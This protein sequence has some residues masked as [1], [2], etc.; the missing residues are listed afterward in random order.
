MVVVDANRKGGRT[1]GR[2]DPNRDGKSGE[3]ATGGGGGGNCG[4]ININLLEMVVVEVVI[5]RYQIGSVNTAKA[6]G[7][8][9][10]FYGG[11]TIHT[12]TNSG[13][14]VVDNNGSSPL[15]VEYIVNR[16]WRWRVEIV[17]AVVVVVVV[18]TNIPGGNDLQQTTIPVVGPGSPKS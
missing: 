5:V 1:T 11:K 13:E 7:G 14:F 6:S 12:F 2:P 18:G 8:S 15:T 4:T 9:V 10:S 3:E 17:V 16:W